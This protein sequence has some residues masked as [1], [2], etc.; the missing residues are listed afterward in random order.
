MKKLKID[1]K[2]TYASMKTPHLD[3]LDTCMAQEHYGMYLMVKKGQMSNRAS[4]RVYLSYEH[5]R[6]YYEARARRPEVYQ[7]IGMPPSVFVYH[8]FTQYPD[9]V[10]FLRD[11]LSHL[12]PVR[13]RFAR[14][15]SIL[16]AMSIYLSI[17]HSQQIRLKSLMDIRTEHQELVWSQSVSPEKTEI[18]SLFFAA[19]GAASEEFRWKRPPTS[20]KKKSLAAVDTSV[21]YQIDYWAKKDIDRIRRR[22]KEYQ[23][24]IAEYEE[25]TLFSLENLSHTYYA[26]MTSHGDNTAGVIS[27]LRKMAKVLYGVD[28]RSWEKIRKGEY[29]Y[30]SSKQRK[31]HIRLKSLSEKGEDIWITNEKM[32]AIW[33]HELSP[34]FP[35]S[36][37]IQPK[38]RRVYTSLRAFIS[39]VGKRVRADDADIRNFYSRIFPSLTD[40]HPLILLLLIRT[41]LN[42]EVLRMWKVGNHDGRYRI[43]T[44]T[45]I[46]L[47]IGGVKYRGNTHQDI[48]LPNS[49]FEKKAMD[50]FEEWLQDIFTK[51]ESDLFFQYVH[52]KRAKV[53]SQWRS[54]GFLTKAQESKR[55][56]FV[57]HDITDDNGDRVTHLDHRRLRTSGNYINYLRGYGEFERQLKLGHQDRGTQ[58]YYTNSE[59]WI[60]ANRHKILR[61]Q[62]NIVRIARG[63]KIDTH[64]G[65]KFYAILA[66]CADPSTPDYPG[67][68]K[69]RKDEVCGDYMKCL[70]MCTKSIVIP[71]IHGPA[72]MAWKKHMEAESQTFISRESWE[73]E[74]AEDYAAAEKVLAGFEEDELRE[75]EIKAHE[76]TELVALRFQNKI[77][78]INE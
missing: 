78:V 34:N 54:G 53:I 2:T 30:K 3:I 24:W 37:E 8:I 76:Y 1:T 46:G 75:S 42:S 33:L 69:L 35:F 71:K 4:L 39:N 47:L 52:T 29:F 32:F 25:R 63:E 26:F 60:N 15:K 56:F 11:V 44:Q 20:G 12:F 17:M 65:H 57:R 59:E 10:D 7:D 9:H 74:Y 68:P 13:E 43:G 49:S 21:I 58:K 19:V 41:N 28:L 48:V 38:Y 5:H 77:K 16:Q 64:Q 66:D 31:E 70:T 50:F 23:G 72:I 18:L 40:M 62:E 73:K 61:T 55:S 14:T 51:S 36:K 45:G 6:E 27:H 67:A 22:R